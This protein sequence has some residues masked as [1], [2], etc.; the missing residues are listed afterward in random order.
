M[1]NKTYVKSRNIWKVS[2]KLP[3]E[4]CPRIK[5]IK[6]VKL[7]GDFNNWDENGITMT[8]SKSVFSTTHEF[9]P[10]QQLEFRYL[11]NGTIWCNDWHADS[12]VA[13][14]YGGENCVLHLPMK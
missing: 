13:N 8:Y 6:S 7:V 3:K 12:Y 1:L 4:E 11:I 5:K 9:A 14:E 2:F 10:G